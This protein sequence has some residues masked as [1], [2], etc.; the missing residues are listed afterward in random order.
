MSR[1]DAF[2]EK[3]G[4]PPLRPGFGRHIRHQH[5]GRW[6]LKAPKKNRILSRNV[7]KK[8]I[9]VDGKWVRV[10]LTTREMRTMLKDAR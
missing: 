2:R 8:R 9:L 6:E 7:H 10:P 4:L 1:G 5:S 3:L